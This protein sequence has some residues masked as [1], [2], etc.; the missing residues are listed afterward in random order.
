MMGVG[1]GVRQG[2]WGSWKDPCMWSR[3]HLVTVMVHDP[4]FW[5]NDLT[6]LGSVPHL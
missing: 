1:M 4:L 6:L 2:H 5:V 3:M